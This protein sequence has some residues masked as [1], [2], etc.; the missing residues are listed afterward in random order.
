MTVINKEREIREIKD[1]GKVLKDIFVWLKENIN[2]GMSTGL[3]DKEIE[4]LILEAGAKPAFKGYK[5]YPAVICASV[6]EV[7]VHG[8]PSDD[9]I[10]KNGDIV[11]ID[12]GVK[13]NGF[14]TD[15][16]RTYSVGEISQDALR[17]MRATR[18]SLDAG[19]EMAVAGN[20][21]SDIS[22]AI[23]EAV[24]KNGYQEVRAF[25][26][27]GIGRALHES[28]E[29]PNWGQKGNG[30]VLEEGLVLAI[31]PMVNIG[32]RELEVLEDGWTAVTKDKQLSSHFEDTII[33]GREK[34]EILT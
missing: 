18:E 22:H 24:K 19:I 32:S 9:V 20:N 27:H 2:E 31:E 13:K 29:V 11:S 12:V 26:G 3:I 23:E 16:A 8:I 7:V 10:L 33:V 5:G 17:L 21:I 14:F 15:A 30:I 1:S 28:P 6:N 25:V 34:A 4:G